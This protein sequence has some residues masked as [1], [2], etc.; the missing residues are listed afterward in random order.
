VGVVVIV[1]ALASFALATAASAVTID[2]ADSWPASAAA[3]PPQEVVAPEPPAVEGGDVAERIAP[4]PP[5]QP[6]FPAPVTTIPQ[7]APNVDVANFG[8]GWPAAVA[9]GVAVLAVLIMSL[10]WRRDEPGWVRSS[11]RR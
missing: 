10:V 2:S 11:D 9:A 4:A 6:F 5:E 1:A 8:V 7:R 3:D